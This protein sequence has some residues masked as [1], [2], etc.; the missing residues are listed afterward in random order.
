LGLGGLSGAADEFSAED[1]SYWESDE[2]K[3]I[4]STYLL[5]ASTPDGD[6]MNS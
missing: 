1:D 5:P 3:D 2:W 4:K 6:Q